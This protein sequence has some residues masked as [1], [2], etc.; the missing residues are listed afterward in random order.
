MGK[1]FNPMTARTVSSLVWCL[2]ALAAAALAT[3]Q[4]K[5]DAVKICRGVP[6]P[7]G[8]VIVALINSPACPSGAYLIRKESAVAV[9]GETNGA[10]GGVRQAQP[11]ASRPRRVGVGALPSSGPPTNEPKPVPKQV[12][13]QEPTLAK[14]AAPPTPHAEGAPV[15]Y[16]LTGPEEVGE[17]EVVRVDTTLV[18]VPVSVRDRDGRFVP[19]L[20][21]E[22]FHLF[23]DGEEQTIAYFEEADKPFTVALML[24]TSGSTGFKLEEIKEEA[25]RF[26]AQLRPQD[27]V[28]VVTFSDEVLLLTE[29]TNDRAV[30]NAVIEANAQTG[31]ATRLYEAID[32]LVRER[33][34]KIKGRKAIVLFTDG[35]D[36]ASHLATYESTLETAE[37][38][39]ALIYPIKYDTFGDVMAQAG[40]GSVSVF[41]T[42]S[43]GGWPSPWGVRTSTSRVVLN[44]PVDDVSLRVMREAYE[45]AD[46]YLHALA[47]K[48]GGRLYRAD[49]PAHLAGAFSMIAE[50]LRHQYSLG[51]YPKSPERAAGERRQIRVRLRRE[52]LA[53]QAR[54]S[55]ISAGGRGGGDV[56]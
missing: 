47:E 30:I 42:R 46:Q 48:T 18:T 32:L 4:A 12:P 20:G 8:Y 10:Q 21:R 37:E 50:E 56:R 13:R 1:G 53:V 45:R 22:D 6:V 41:S 49:D 9:K 2:A 34:N 28:L 43:R 16:P 27:R 39:D 17:G 15:A 31:N 35:V 3:G 36:T 29:A 24:D 11:P 19:Y 25:I 51:Y 23:E 40:R 55:Y 14:G 38:L 54:N 5:R 33:L 52:G 26:A 7:E 44:S